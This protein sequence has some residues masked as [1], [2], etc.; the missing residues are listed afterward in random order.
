M[1]AICVHSG[2]KLHLNGRPLSEVQTIAVE[3]EEGK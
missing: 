3:M 1:V 2:Y